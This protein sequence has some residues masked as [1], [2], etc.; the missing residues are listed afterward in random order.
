MQGFVDLRLN[1]AAGQVD[2]SFWPSFTDI[3]AVVVMIFLIATSV[4]ILRNWELL[5]QVTETVAAEQRAAELARSASEV[6]ATLEEQLANAQHQISMQRLDLLRMSEENQA[7]AE[8]LS[9]TEQRLAQAGAERQALNQ[10]LREADSTN[11]NLR[12]KLQTLGGQYSRLQTQRDELEGRL[13]VADST[14]R[15]LREQLQSR[16]NETSRLRTQLETT[17][18][19]LTGLRRSYADQNREL[20]TLRTSSAQSSQRLGELKTDYDELRVKYDR[21]VRPART[22]QGKYVVEVRYRKSGR[23]LDIDLKEPGDQRFRNVS[24]TSLHKTLSTLKARGPE[25]LYIKIIFP[26][27]SGLTYAEAWKFTRELLSQYD[28]YYHKQP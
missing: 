10:R 4:L 2:E 6:N 11:V 15:S 19:T 12:D 5:Q 25:D 8:R 23:A 22:A 20:A 7:L 14:N 17:N 9:Q 27:D 16:A 3:M 28:Y 18:T 24:E 21:L 26:E 13:D 1:R